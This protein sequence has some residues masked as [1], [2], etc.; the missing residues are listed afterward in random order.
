MRAVTCRLGEF[1]ALRI[2]N[3]RMVDEGGLSEG[4]VTE[5]LRKMHLTGRGAHQVLSTNDQDRPLVQI[6]GQ[7]GDLVGWPAVPLQDHGITHRPGEIDPDLAA[8]PG[9]DRYLAQLRKLDAPG[10]TGRVQRKSKVPADPWIPFPAPGLP[11]PFP[12]TVAGIKQ[13]EVP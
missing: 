5:D 8:W 9:R 10:H 13:S 2:P 12:G 1:P 4:P 7:R 3:E 11:D 6:I